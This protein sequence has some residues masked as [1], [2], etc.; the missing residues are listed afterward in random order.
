MIF[1]NKHEY[2]RFEIKKMIEEESLKPGDKLPTELQFQEKYDVSRHTV[3][4]A[5]SNLEN[6][7]VIYKEQG[8]GSFVSEKKLKSKEIGVITTYMSDYI[9]PY[10]IRGIEKELTEQGYTM[11][12]T[13]TDNNHDLEKRALKMM[14]D[15]DIDGIIVEPTKSA[16]YNPNIGEYLKLK[17][18]GIPTVMINATYAELD[19]PAVILDDYN[20]GYMATLELIENNH[21]NIGGIFKIDDMQGKERLKGYMNACYDN[22]VEYNSK[23][24]LVYETETLNELM[25]Q[26]VTKLVTENNVT[27][28]VTY[29]DKVAND[30]LEIIWKNDLKVPDDFSIVSHDNS[31]LSEMSSTQLTSVDHPKSDLGK[32]AAELV[33]TSVNNGNAKIEDYVFKPEL[34]R[35]TSVKKI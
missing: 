7:G 13:S 20:A 29:N 24:I 22:D 19:M 12:L 31:Y 14:L 18:R 3:R 30:L 1:M 10:I 2:L 34:V 5:L 25:D 32:K 15:R 35:R 28:I 4:L 16:L 21:T 9:F 6:E 11:I 26:S 33:L 8:L 23:N 17:K 27:G